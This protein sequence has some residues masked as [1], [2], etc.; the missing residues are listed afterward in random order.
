MKMWNC[1]NMKVCKYE[2]GRVSRL[3]SR[4]LMILGICIFAHCAA[5]GGNAV[6]PQFVDDG[7]TETAPDPAPQKQG[8]ILTDKATFLTFAANSAK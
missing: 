7:A 6:N 5:F 2:N 4:V 3:V 8:Y 1:G